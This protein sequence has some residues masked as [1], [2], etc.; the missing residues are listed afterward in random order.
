[1]SNQLLQIMESD[2]EEPPPLKRHEDSGGGS[3]SR[4]GGG[5]GGSA[6]G[7]GKSNMDL[8][9]AAYK[10]AYDEFRDKKKVCCAYTSTSS[11]SFPCA[12]PIVVNPTSPSAILPTQELKHKKSSMRRRAEDM[13][14]DEEQTQKQRQEILAGLRRQAAESDEALD[15]EKRRQHAVELEL[16]TL[17]G[18]L[19][20]V[21][22]EHS[23]WETDHR[24]EADRELEEAWVDLR[25]LR[26]KH[27]NVQ[28]ATPSGPALTDRTGAPD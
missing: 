21:A 9:E 4:H 12:L 1:M 6:S 23:Q 7:G 25:R 5:G 11:A 10:Q 22:K 28:R 24:V 2:E 16:G 15:A 8:V 3:S 27:P 17:R 14:Y 18:R 19:A 26:R 13:E 20:H